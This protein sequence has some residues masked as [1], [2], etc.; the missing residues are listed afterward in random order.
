MIT[1]K[2]KKKGH[3][4]LSPKLSPTDLGQNYNTKVVPTNFL[5]SKIMIFSKEFISDTT[6]NLG[7]VWFV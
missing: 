5:I 4:K 2:K 3:L 6:K 7:C 1:K